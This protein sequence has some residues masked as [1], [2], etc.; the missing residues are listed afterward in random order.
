MIGWSNARIRRGHSQEE[1]ACVSKRKEATGVPSV[2]YNWVEY[3]GELARPMKPD[4]LNDIARVIA[5]GGRLITAD[6]ICSTGHSEVL[7]RG[8]TFHT[9]TPYIFM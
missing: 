4:E 6:N 3:S 7:S 9:S 2:Q 1:N 8:F 5:K